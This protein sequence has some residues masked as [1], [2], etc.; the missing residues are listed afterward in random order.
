[1]YSFHVK[2][3]PNL[4]SRFALLQFSK[5]KTV[6]L[7]ICRYSAR[8]A[9]PLLVHIKR[10]RALEHGRAAERKNPALLELLET[11]TLKAEIIFK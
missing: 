9:D 4:F 10:L 2:K 3:H 11:A 7:R 8:G 6:A 5:R 1:V